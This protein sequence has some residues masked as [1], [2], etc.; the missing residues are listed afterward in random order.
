MTF[1]ESAVSILAEPFAYW[2]AGGPLLIPIA[3]VSVGIWGYLLRCRRFFLQVLRESDGLEE[4]PPVTER[5]QVLDDV[6]RRPA[7]GTGLAAGQAPAVRED[8]AGADLGAALTAH[9]ERQ[10]ARLGRDLVVLAALTGAA[11]LLGL[12]GT[13]LGMTRT[14]GAVSLAQG[15]TAGSVAA[16]ISQA[17][18]TTQFGLVVA[19]PG[20]F[21]LVRLRRLLQHIRARFVCVRLNVLRAA[22]G[23]R[24]RRQG[25][26]SP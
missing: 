17:L 9:E 24:G 25:G 5:R 3:L 15:K 18:I 2:R 21:G 11:P 7:S 23:N 13:V 26:D 20:V 12:L 8:V 22:E 6:L 19:I 16:G 1:A 10:L 14:F 4:H